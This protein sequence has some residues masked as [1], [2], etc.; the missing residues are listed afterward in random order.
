MHLD[1]KTGHRP[2]RSMDNVNASCVC[3]LWRFRST[4]HRFRYPHDLLMLEFISESLTQAIAITLNLILALNLTLTIMYSLLWTLGIADSEDSGHLL[5][6]R[7]EQVEK[8]GRR[9]WCNGG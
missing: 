4:I 5:V 9:A 3:L 7:A 2:Q 8:L 6:V 1:L